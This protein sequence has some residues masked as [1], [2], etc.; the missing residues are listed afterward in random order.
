MTWKID[1][2]VEA[3]W[4]ER[5]RPQGGVSFAAHS[6]P[7]PSEGLLSGDLQQGWDPYDVWLR[8]IHEPRRQ[9]DTEQR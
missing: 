9:R 2:K 8:H 4:L 6:E 7:G 3:S 1:S 5:A